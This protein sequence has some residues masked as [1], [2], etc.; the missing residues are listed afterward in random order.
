MVLLRGR[1]LQAYE[2]SLPRIF[3]PAWRRTVSLQD[4]PASLIRYLILELIPFGK[5]TA[6]PEIPLHDHCHT[7]M[8]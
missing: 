1:T 5:T 3:A 4:H 7:I 8:L 2:S 6:T